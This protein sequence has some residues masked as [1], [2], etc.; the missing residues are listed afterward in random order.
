MQDRTL[1]LIKLLG[2]SKSTFLFGPR[3]VGKTTLAM[4]F[5]KE[6]STIQ[7]FLNINL[8]RGI[9]FSRYLKNPSLLA[10]EIETILKKNEQLTVCIDEVQKLPSL[11]DEVH[12]LLVTYP[13]RLQFLLTGASARKLKRG[14]ANLLAGRAWTLHLY[15]LTHLE[16]EF[17]LNKALIYGTL[18]GVYLED[19][20][21]ERTLNAYV[22]T[23][24][25]EEIQI[26][27][28]IRNLQAFAR[29]L[30]VAAQM[31]GDPVNYSSIGREVGVSAN[32][33]KEYYQIL[34]DTLLVFRID[35]WTRSVRKQLL[36]SPKYYFFDCGILNTING[37]I[38]TELKAG[39]R[40]FGDLFET[41]IILEIIR[42]NHY[43]ETGFQFHYWRTNSGT[44]VDLI[45]R[46]SPADPLI[47]IEIK[48]G[49]APGPEDLSGLKSFLSENP[50]TKPI[51]LSRTPNAY[52]IEG[53]PILP[54]MEGIQ[55]ALQNKF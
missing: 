9:Q 30:D 3:G 29:F 16:C 7:Q 54:W 19:Q 41:L 10:S 17:D 53:I 52:E 13:K 28:R 39:S 12:H 42:L 18:P 20:A 49:L 25:K 6:M 2:N 47:A 38:R 22:N 23:Y 24:L 46:K 43:W 1:N 48:S 4:H 8:L 14:G 15:P 37:D 5:L 44:E 21:P 35:G 45:L 36:K 31:N 40:R 26:E 50:N 33:I 55:S 51:V 27:S 32:T 11:L 34:E